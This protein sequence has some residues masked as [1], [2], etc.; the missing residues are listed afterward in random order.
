MVKLVFHISAIYKRT[1]SKP[2]SPK[3]TTCN[4]LNIKNDS[5]KEFIQKY[6]YDIITG[7]TNIGCH[8]DDIEFKL[9]NYYAKTHSSQGEMRTI[10]L[11]VK[12]ALIEFVNEYRSEYPVLL[13]DDVL[14]ELDESRQQNLMKYIQSKT[15]TFIT[16]TN[17][18]E[19]NLDEIK[20]YQIYRIQDGQIKE[21]DSNG[22]KL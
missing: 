17:I 20:E 3:K 22:T 21:S 12:L 4:S 8:R 16:S 2:A 5:K 19:I 14:S 10:V 15:Q 1:C 9:D 6:Q 11:A 18:N 7:M 13:L